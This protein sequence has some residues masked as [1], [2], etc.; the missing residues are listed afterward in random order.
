VGKTE[1]L[2][3]VAERGVGVVWR[4]EGVLRGGGKDWSEE[5]IMCEGA[6]CGPDRMGGK[7]EVLVA[8]RWGQAV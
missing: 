4:G 2:G 8:G 1:G 5:L 6:R 3:G 7:R